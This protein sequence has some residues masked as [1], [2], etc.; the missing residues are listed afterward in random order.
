MLRMLSSSYTVIFDYDE[1][2]RKGPK[3]LELTYENCCSGN[4]PKNRYDL[5][6]HRLAKRNQEIK[7]INGHQL[8]K[9][10][11]HPENRCTL[12]A[13]GNY[14]HL[15]FWIICSFF[16]YLFLWKCWMNQSLSGK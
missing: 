13:G 7:E 14:Q 8:R 9:K 10:N 12:A 6:L 1:S 3:N 2:S 4:E 5:A 16:F 15:S 11:R